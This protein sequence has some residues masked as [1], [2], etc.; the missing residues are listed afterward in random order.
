M[1]KI[2]IQD[3]DEGA[4]SQARIIAVIDVVPQHTDSNG[5]VTSYVG[6]H[7]P[8]CLASELTPEI[9]RGTFDRNFNVTAPQGD[10]VR[11]C[12]KIFK[13][14]NRQPHPWGGK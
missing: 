2:V 4:V 9:I 6:V 11:T 5:V 14:L 7:R 13:G 12:L 10:W 1:I 3:I 8:E